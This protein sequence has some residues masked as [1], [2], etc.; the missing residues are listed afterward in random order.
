MFNLDNSILMEWIDPSTY[1][2]HSLND[3]LN[4]VAAASSVKTRSLRFCSS[5]VNSE[6]R[7]SMMLVWV[8][9]R[10]MISS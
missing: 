5:A 9:K 2:F 8:S 7:Q 10:A 6:M 3:T 4:V 1:D